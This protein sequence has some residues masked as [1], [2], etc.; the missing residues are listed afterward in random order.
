M[1]LEVDSVHERGVCSALR[2][3]ALC[4]AYARF[5]C[6]LHCALYCA[7]LCMCALYCAVLCICAL[8]MYCRII[9]SCSIVLTNKEES[10]FGLSPFSLSF[11]A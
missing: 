10:E 7:V 8:P 2:S 11:P 3:V 1:I 9:V 5:S 6:A 4:Y